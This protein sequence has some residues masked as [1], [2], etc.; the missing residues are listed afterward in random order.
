MSVEPRSHSNHPC[1]ARGDAARQRG[2]A[3]TEYI[4][5]IGLIVLPLAMAFNGLQDVLKDLLKEIARL[6]SGPGV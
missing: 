1:C 5:I 4:L 3:A 2:Q 6:L